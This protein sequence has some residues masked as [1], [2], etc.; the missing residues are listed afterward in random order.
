M[1]KTSSLTPLQ[2]QVI[3]NKAT[4][5]PFSGEFVEVNSQGSY[6]CRNCG[7]VLFRGEYQFHSGC[8][9]ASFDQ[10]VPSSITQL[11]DADGKRSEIV[12]SCCN[13]H[14]GH[15][16]YGEGFTQL[17]TRHCVNSF[18]LDYVTNQDVTMS[19]EII[20]AAGCFWGVEY[21][22]K[23]LNGVLLTQVGYCG[24]EVD[25]PQYSQVKQQ[26]TGHL[27]VVRVIFDPK[28]LSLIEL[29]QY[30]FEI[31]DFTQVDGQGPDIGNQYLSAIFYYENRQQEIA[32][33][34][35][36]QLTVKG[37]QVATKLLPMQSFWIGE[38]YHRNYYDRQGNIPYCHS[39]IKRF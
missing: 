39:Y 26:T 4:E 27:E 20:L 16:F 31:H 2:Y 11:L 19:E 36:N 23:R 8:G 12:C 34:I 18:A 28:R 24:G 37:Y 25:N 1:L 3:I 7:A 29:L 5:I 32:Q 9:W 6:L 17:N 13:G 21:Y 15:V 38:E 35:I 30:F 10:A 14:L 22:L 33:Q